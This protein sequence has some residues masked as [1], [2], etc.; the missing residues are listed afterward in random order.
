[1]TISRRITA[2]I[3]LILATAVAGGLLVGAASAQGTRTPTAS[4]Y[5]DEIADAKKEQQSNEQKL[6][7]L[8]SALE[9]TDAA[10]VEANRQL[11]ELEARL[12]VVQAELE[13]AQERYDSAVLEQKIVADKLAAAQ[14]QDE[15]LTAQIAKDEERIELIRQAIA[16]LARESYVGTDISSLGVVFGA[17]SAQEFVDDF[18]ARSSAER[19]QANALAEMEQIAAVNVNRA[20]RQEAVREVIEELKRQADALVVETEAARVAAEEKKAEVEKLLDEAQDLRDYLESKRQEY[21]AKQA[22]LEAQQEAVRNELRDLLAKKAAEEAE[23]ST[24]TPVGKGIMNFPTKVP[25]VT[26]SYGWRL[27]PVY[28]YYR[29]HAGTDFRAYC[30]TPIYAAADGEVLWAKTVGGFGQQVMLN[31]GR[32]NGDSV[33]SSY[34][35]LSRFAVSTGQYVLKGD[36][37]GYSGTTGTSTACH[38][39]FEVYV[40]GSTVDPMSILGPVP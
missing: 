7:D 38:L 40:N 11:K 9:N 18:A 22:E 20:A 19:V 13:L 37:V 35:H 34:N 26:S 31:H 15:A 3:A 32:Y 33:A 4:S 21:L 8:E 17:Q 14:A 10:I 36:L 27:H 25:Y 24:S 2:L 12:P 16:V 29:L 1:M 5:D 39:H 6:D 30:G 23:Q 28:G